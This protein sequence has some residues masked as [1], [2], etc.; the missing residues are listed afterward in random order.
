M[1]AN[2]R[3][4]EDAVDPVPA[5]DDQ[6]IA[7]DR[8]ALV[9]EALDMLDLEHRVLI[10]GHEIEGHSVPELAA[11]LNV[12]TFTAYSR[13]RVAREKFGVAVRRLQIQ[14]GER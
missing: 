14:R 12:P 4:H 10:V 3:E 13:L 11:A 6:L 5:I 2:I 9:N 7:L 1:W 8:K